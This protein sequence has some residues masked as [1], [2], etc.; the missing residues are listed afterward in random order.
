LG[1]NVLGTGLTGNAFG[2]GLGFGANPFL[3]GVAGTTVGGTGTVTAG[4]V[5]A[6]GPG[7]TLIRIR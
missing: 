5:F 6:I 3:T 1:A 7:G 4:S 2:L